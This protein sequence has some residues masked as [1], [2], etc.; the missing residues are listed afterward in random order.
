M[1]AEPNLTGGARVTYTLAG[2]VL[3]WWGLSQTD[4]DW[5]HYLLP[6]IGAAI[7]VEGSIGYCVICAAFGL[8][9]KRT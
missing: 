7:F 1:A 4:S 6:M 5:L 8:G 9:K 3:V 2:L